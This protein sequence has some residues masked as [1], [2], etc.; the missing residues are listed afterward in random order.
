MKQKANIRKILFRLTGLLL[1]ALIFVGAFGLAGIS[2]KGKN[3]LQDFF[4]IGTSEEQILELWNV[5]T[6]E[7]G[8]A[9]KAGFLEKVALEFEKK[10][11]GTYVLVRAMDAEEC[12]A[13]LLGGEMPDMFSFSGVVA[14]TIKPHLTELEENQ[15]I[16]STLLASATTTQNELLAMPWCMS[17]YALMTT[18][19]KMS[20]SGKTG[21]SLL[22]NVFEYGYVKKLKKS[23]KQIYSLVYGE[24]N[25]NSPQKAL[26]E[27]SKV[28]GVLQHRGDLDVYPKTSELTGY[29]AYEKWVLGDSVLLLGTARDLVRFEGRIAAGK[30]QNS[31]IYYCSYFTDLVQYMG[32][33]KSSNK[34]KQKNAEEFVKFLC[35]SK[36]QLNLASIGLFSVVK[37]DENLYSQG[38]LSGMEKALKSLS[39]V[40][41]IFV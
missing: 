29:G 30:D 18:E 3:K 33:V 17:G 14:N 5:D 12:L 34:N 37:S 1:I 4:G 38:L 13:R 16:L 11:K 25:G 20:A 6:F 26:F 21:E 24:K 41:N 23:N 10:H 9:S 36:I 19:S 40:D 15:Q 8:I 7:G 32:V 22:A 35:S 39:L 28:K 27:E 2:Q 31:E